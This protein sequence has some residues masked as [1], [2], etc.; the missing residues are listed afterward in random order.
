[1][2]WPLVRWLAAGSVPAALAAVALCQRLPP[3][4]REEWLRRAV[5]G[6]LLV[7]ALLTVARALHARRGGLPPAAV[8]RLRRP[9]T[10][11]VGALTGALVGLT[12]VGS[13]SL[14]MAFLAVSYPMASRRLVGTD[15]AHALA[16]TAAS[17]LAHGLAGNVN[18]ALALAVIAGALPGALLGAALAGRV[19]DAVLRGGLAVALGV[20]GVALLGAQR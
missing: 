4:L 12:S 5:A 9:L 8:P 6:A 1:V 13:G 20:A 11:A 14:L 16:L 18:W 2:E 3:A 19:R 10:L 7:S 17:A 15:L